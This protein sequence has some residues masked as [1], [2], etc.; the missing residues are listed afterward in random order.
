MDLEAQETK[1]NTFIKRLLHKKSPIKNSK[2]KRSNTGYKS[3]TYLK[4]KDIYLAQLYVK[5]H[6]KEKGMAIFIGH[7]P[8]LEEAI[9][10]RND[11]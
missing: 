8:T 10:I 9:K 2:S 3:I 1:M 11:Y 5:K 6:T 4:D 7:Y